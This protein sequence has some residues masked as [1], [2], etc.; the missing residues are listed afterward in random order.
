MPE[1]KKYYAFYSETAQKKCKMHEYDSN[2]KSIASD[3]KHAESYSLHYMY[4]AHREASVP[5][6]RKCLP[7]EVLSRV[8]APPGR[9][10]HA[11]TG[12]GAIAVAVAARIAGSV[13]HRVAR[14]ADRVCRGCRKRVWKSVEVFCSQDSH[15]QEI[16]GWLTGLS[17]A[18]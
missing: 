2:C 9:V 5:W 17:N 8:T 18:F 4:A 6:R 13:A 16:H 11:H 7:T 10:H 12:T 1:K 3:R 15:S 14:S